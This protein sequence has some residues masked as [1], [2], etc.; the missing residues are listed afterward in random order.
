MKRPM[1]FLFIMAL[2]LALV[3]PA[4]AVGQ[5]VLYFG[6]TPGHWNALVSSL[7]V[8]G[9][10]RSSILP[11]DLPYD[12]V[13]VDKSS[14]SPRD[15]SRLR[16]FTAR[17]GG[18]AFIGG[19]PYWL[20]GSADLSPIAEWFGAWCYTNGPDCSPATASLCHPFGCW[21]CVGEAVAWSSCRWSG[22]AAVADLTSDAVAMARWP[23]GSI[24]AF[25][26]A[27]GSGRVY[28]QSI[29]DSCLFP[30]A[31]RWLAGSDP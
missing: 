28:F 5:S 20:A 11:Q 14:F 18:V 3:L 29:I 15:A 2:A 30:S 4:M 17:G 7:G 13:I 6:D 23:D 10:W 25:A 19:A 8:S 1:K 31:V 24:F 12:V 22:P 9:L 21:L 16:A 26:H 27:Y